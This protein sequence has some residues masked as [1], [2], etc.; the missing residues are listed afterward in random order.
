MYILFDDDDNV[1]SITNARRPFTHALCV[2]DASLVVKTID[3]QTVVHE[4]TA[5]GKP[6]YVDK[7]GVPTTTAN[8]NQPLFT[9]T[10]NARVAS[11]AREP[12]LFTRLDVLAYIKRGLLAGTA[13]EN[14]QIIDNNFVENIDISGQ[15]AS[16]LIDV[17]TDDVVVHPTGVL[18]LKSSTLAPLIELLSVKNVKYDIGLLT[19]GELKCCQRRAATGPF[20]NVNEFKLSK[21]MSIGFTND[22]DDDV[23]VDYIYIMW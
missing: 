14:C 1:I 20:K 6:L 4:H 17:G 19:D 7:H 15:D 13:F 23:R 18:V 12:R 8:G 21:T 5:T 3:A 2:D 22:G 16:M 11:L 10:P 9:M